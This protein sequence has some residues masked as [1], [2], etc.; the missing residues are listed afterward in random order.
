[1]TRN[2]RV[3]FYDYD[4]LCLVEEC[5]FRAVPAM[6]EEDETRP[7]DEWLYAGSDD[8]FPELFPQFLGIAPA[9][10]KRLCEVHGEIFDPAWWRDVQT[11]LAAGEHFDV[12]PYP[13]AVRLPQAR[14]SKD[15]LR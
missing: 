3:L 1:V 12:P 15:D 14:E 6:R 7:L 4:E 2:G 5:K 13:D 9:L 10:R 11:R 8:V